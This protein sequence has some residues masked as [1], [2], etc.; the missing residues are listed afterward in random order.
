MTN[1]LRSKMIAKAICDRKFDIPEW[2][3]E[4]I[5]EGVIN[6]LIPLTSHYLGVS[7]INVTGDHKN[8]SMEPYTSGTKIK[9]FF[10]HVRGKLN[11]GGIFADI[12]YTT[13]DGIYA[14]LLLNKRGW[15]R[16]SS[17]ITEND[18]S[19][20]RFIKFLSKYL[21]SSDDLIDYTEMVCDSVGLSKECIIELVYDALEK[22]PENYRQERLFR[23]TEALEVYDNYRLVQKCLNMGIPAFFSDGDISGL[24]QYLSTVID[25]KWNYNI[26]V[27]IVNVQVHDDDKDVIEKIVRIFKFNNR[28]IIVFAKSMIVN[29]NTFKEIFNNQ[30]KL[31]NSLAGITIDKSPIYGIDDFNDLILIFGKNVYGIPIPIQT[32]FII[33]GGDVKTM[34]TE[35]GRLLPEAS[36]IKSSDQLNFVVSHISIDDLRFL[37]YNSTDFVKNII[38]NQD[39]SSPIYI[40]ILKAL[41]EY[42]INESLWKVLNKPNYDNGIIDFRETIVRKSITLLT[43]DA[44]FTSVPEAMLYIEPSALFVT[45]NI[46]PENIPFIPISK[47]IPYLPSIISQ[48]EYV[49]FNR[50]CDGV[51]VS[52]T[53][54]VTLNFILKTITNYKKYGY[55]GDVEEIDHKSFINKHSKGD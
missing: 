27:D 23:I 50:Y 4:C 16:V 34:F 2:M 15:R 32:K 40:K 10:D 49:R 6:E 20:N 28:S 37:I 5:D 41:F 51:Y 7:K 26:D 19:K 13:N 54:V 11:I 55:L 31:I 18:E 25:S 53:H 48:N 21:L 29:P 43:L 3:Y 45:R 30:D 9:E 24:D 14:G 39:I 42:P 35:N 17:I 36:I 52:L 22:Y 38:S 33:N 46:S 8:I 1:E 47:L 44:I 12:I